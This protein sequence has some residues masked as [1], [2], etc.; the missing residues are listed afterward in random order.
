M[1]ITKLDPVPALI[2]I[3]LQKGIASAPTVH[4]AAVVARAAQLAQ[5]F[6]EHHLPVVLVN[7]TGGVPAAPTPERRSCNAKTTGQNLFPNCSANLVITPSASNDGA[8]SL[9]LL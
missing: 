9:E 2:V 5:A 6:R 1:P 8:P 7:V 4:P 3:D